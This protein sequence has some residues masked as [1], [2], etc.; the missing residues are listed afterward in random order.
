MYFGL[1]P[2]AME[3][4]GGLPGSDAVVG[5]QGL[6]PPLALVDRPDPLALK[7]HEGDAQRHTA[8]GTARAGDRVGQSSL[9]AKLAIDEEDPGVVDGRLAGRGALRRV[10]IK[11]KVVAALEATLSPTA[12]TRRWIGHCRSSRCQTPWYSCRLALG[13][14]R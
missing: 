1:A 13:S 3:A 5:L 8:A 6:Q 2:F 10:E 12:P 9:S 11:I 14:A 7:V 4:G